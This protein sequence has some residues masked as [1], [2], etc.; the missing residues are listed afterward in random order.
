LSISYN[1]TATTTTASTQKSSSVNSSLI[2]EINPKQV[3]IMS[4]Y[5]AEKSLSV[6]D[7]TAVHAMMRPMR[8]STGNLYR[9]ICIDTERDRTSGSNDIN[10]DKQS[11][12]S[13]SDN[14]VHSQPNA[15][16]DSS[17]NSALPLQSESVLSH[18]NSHP[19]GGVK[20]ASTSVHHNFTQSGGGSIESHNGIKGPPSRARQSSTHDTTHS[21][22]GSS[23][24]QSNRGAH[25]TSLSHL[26]PSVSSNGIM[27][28]YDNNTQHRPI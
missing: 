1:D 8:T 17:T 24:K 15:K 5:Y 26:I 25:H 12:T 11:D 6:D 16:T 10:N 21:I 9:I 3:G 18:S 27:I 2:E 4:Q 22:K 28:P 7:K 19:P 20:T 14:Q 13:Y 23:S